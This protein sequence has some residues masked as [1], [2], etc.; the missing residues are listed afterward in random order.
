MKDK[1]LLVILIV[2]LF[3]RLYNFEKSF[4]FAHDQDLYSW[5]A[6]DI[7]VNHHLRLV[8]QLTSVDG[9]FI[10]SFYYYLMAA[11]YFVFK[12]NPLSAC[13]P[14]TI[15][16]LFSI[17]SIYWVV[18]SNFGKKCGRISA[19]IYAISF[20]I[21][22]FDRWSVPTQPT[23]V[24]SIWFM[25]V[26][27]AL[28][29]GNLKYLPLYG[30]LCGFVWQLHIALLPI[31]PIP[32]VAY[33]IG[34]NKINL[35]WDK[36]Y[37]KVVLLSIL[38]FAVTLSP[39]VVF[40]LKHNFL[41]IKSMAVGI[42][43]NT[44]GLTGMSK[45]YKVI[46]A[47]GREFQQR[48]WIGDFVKYDVVFW[49]LLVCMLIC[50]VVYKKIDIRILSMFALWYL[51]TI[52]AQYTSKRVVSEYYFTNLVPIYIVVTALFLENFA[53]KNIVY[54][55]ALIYFVI[56]GWWLLSKS[57]YDQS[58]FYRKGVVEFIKYDAVKNDYP[59]IAVNFISDP[60]V[61]VGFRYL[62]WYYGVDL[63]KPGTPGVPV[64]NV[65]I[66]WQLSMSENPRQ[67]GR[68]GVLLPVKTK[69]IISNKECKRPEYILDPLL[70]YTE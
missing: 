53:V 58:Y 36:K 42:N 23:L 3:F 44:G 12:M 27:L 59:C 57:D 64:Y 32:I 28:G 2:G 1:W 50:L 39:F 43:K 14:L 30:F 10:G 67:F 69:T 62:F 11:F 20:G 6:K 24:W 41:Q 31:L 16:G 38:I 9:V 15:I 48:F 5:I 40:E 54:L 49:I 21:A 25:A 56:N 46:D 17:W 68:F 51:L 63:V 8:G 13:I 7:V 37:I 4:Y 29:K 34:K 33:I 55:L 65:P 19:Y 47:S 45:I 35:L 22:S 60:G 66:P 18:S 52:L 61:G 26:I 70:G